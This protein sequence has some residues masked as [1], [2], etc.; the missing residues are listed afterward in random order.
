MVLGGDALPVKKPDA[1]H[2]RAV[3]DGLGADGHA[4]M[5]GDSQ[6]DLSAARAT[7]IPCILVSFG[8][9]QVPA[10]QLGADLVIDRMSGLLDALSDLAAGQL[11]TARGAP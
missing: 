3:L 5:V 2:I 7:G 4:V 1:G 6:N 9:T 10:R 8:Y 11:D